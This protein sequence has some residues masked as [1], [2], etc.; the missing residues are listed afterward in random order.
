MEWWDIVIL[1][2]T[3]LVAL[4]LLWR[5][6]QHYQKSP[7][8]HKFDLYYMISF[9]VLLVAG[10]LLIFFTY[11]VL[12]NELVVIVAALIPLGLSVGLVNEFYPKYGLGYLM[13]ALLGLIAIAVTRYTGPETAATIILATVHGIAGLIIFILPIYVAVKGR[14]V[15]D[16]LWVGIG[17]ALI[18]LGG[19]ALA[20]LKSGSQ[21]LFFSA[22]FVFTILAP[23]LLLM[24]LAYT[25]GFVKK[26]LA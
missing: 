1:L 25:Y 23:L 22:D 16:F 26:M 15:T 11:D 10:L 17:G 6:Y 24:A 20:Y 3:G 4:Y 9:A 8:E 19:I 12:G 5:F 21:L 18:G 13:F 14:V 7:S 2:A